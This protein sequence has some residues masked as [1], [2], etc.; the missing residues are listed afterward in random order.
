MAMEYDTE[1]HAVEN[2]SSRASSEDV[3]VQET[4]GDGIYARE[5]LLDPD[6]E[7]SLHR[8]LSA[9]QIQMIAV[10]ASQA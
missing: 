8:G 3:R 10:R 5:E 1:K 6:K 4:D 2:A 9:R 7:E